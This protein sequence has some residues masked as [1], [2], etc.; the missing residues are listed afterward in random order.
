MGLEFQAKCNSSNTVSYSKRGESIF[1]SSFDSQF[2]SCALLRNS[3]F[4]HRFE[5][6]VLQ[7]NAFAAVASTKD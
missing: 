3:S 5:F 4:K 6:F 7:I 1:S 2:T